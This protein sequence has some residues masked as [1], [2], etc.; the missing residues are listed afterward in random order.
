MM[1]LF[2][3]IDPTPGMAERFIIEVQQAKA[4]TVRQRVLRNKILHFAGRPTG[5]AVN[6]GGPP[7]S[8]KSGGLRRDSFD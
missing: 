7:E 5:D 6:G 1:F 4:R 2:D 3:F 8:G